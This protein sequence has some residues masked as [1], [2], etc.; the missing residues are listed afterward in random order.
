MR[1]PNEFGKSAKKAVTKELSENSNIR[2]DIV[3]QFDMFQPYSSTDM[4][5]ENDGDMLKPYE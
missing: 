2:F 1:D 3:D 5:S 4:K